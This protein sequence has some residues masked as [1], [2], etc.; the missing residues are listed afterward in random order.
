[1]SNLP[2]LPVIPQNKFKSVVTET[3]V[4]SEDDTFIVTEDVETKKQQKVY[5]YKKQNILLGYETKET[6]F[7]TVMVVGDAR[8]GK[9]QFIKNIVT[10][11]N[12]EQMETYS[13]TPE[14]VDYNLSV[15]FEDT[16]MSIDFIDS[17][18]FNEK[19]QDAPRSNAKIEKVI[20]DKLKKMTTKVDVIFIV[21]QKL[22]EESVKAIEIC[23]KMFGTTSTPNMH[24]LF[25]HF[26]GLDSTVELAY[27]DQFKT[28][29]HLKNIAPYFGDR[30]LFTGCIAKNMTTHPDQMK[31]VV[32]QQIE[33]NKK[34]L[35]AIKSSR[36][37]LLGD[38]VSSGVATE[39]S[40]KLILN[41][42][43]EKYE[44]LTIDI[45]TLQNLAKSL[46]V[47][48]TKNCDVKEIENKKTLTIDK[49]STILSKEESDRLVNI[50]H[51]A[52]AASVWKPISD[53][54]TQD[55]IIKSAEID[56]WYED[57]QQMLKNALIDIQT[58]KDKISQLSKVEIVVQGFNDKITQSKKSKEE[59]DGKFRK[60]KIEDL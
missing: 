45:A 35:K 14:P 59:E 57:A 58:V 1:M 43:V 8:I 44:S 9:S 11:G 33:R 7:K 17:P 25:T 5:N 27:I 22:T 18:G 47:A 12:I 21:V 26:E 16:T 51:A 46:Q 4:I 37:I 39:Q 3:K 55:L 48:A 10:P 28:D 24:I 34:I 30:I 40:P 20:S 32:K 13:I 15:I 31:E 36:P 29:K 60:D 23:V 49:I 56:K 54:K 41:Q 42:V 38:M 50:Y 19:T 2:S 6:L 53:L 52:A